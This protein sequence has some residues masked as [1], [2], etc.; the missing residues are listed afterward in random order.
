MELFS[1]TL[2][3]IPRDV[4]PIE[5]VRRVGVRRKGGAEGLVGLTR[6]RSGGGPHDGTQTLTFYTGLFDRL[7]PAA[8][9][10]VIAHELAHAWL[11]EHKWPEES[12]RREREADALARSWGFGAE[13]D[14]LD[15]EAENTGGSRY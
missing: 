1:E 14:Q 5:S 7:S 12:K 11:N 15:G 8:K 10:A 3:G 2:A 6:W 13:L 4:A 9:R